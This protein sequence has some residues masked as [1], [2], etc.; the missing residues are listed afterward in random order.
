MEIWIYL[1]KEVLRYVCTNEL[2]LFQDKSG[3]RYNSDSLF[4]YWFINLFTCKGSI[5]DIG[6]GCGI[7]GLLIK[8]DFV[9][10][11]VDMIDIQER[12]I[13]LSKKN[14]EENSLHVNIKECDFLNLDESKKYDI[15]ISNPPFYHSGVKKSENL[16]IAKSR[17]SENLPF[18]DFI[19]K[20]FK[21]L[22][23]KGY[24]YFCYDAKQLPFILKA[25]IDAN[26]GTQEICFLHPKAHKEASLV[27]IRA[28]KSSKALCKVL[29]P[30]VINNEN[31]YTQKAKEVFIKANTL[32][33]EFK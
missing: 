11:D 24:I 25:L 6:C 32:S 29:P 9:S 30:F 22:K 33:C 15:A 14:A 13:F 18:G 8:R 10:C 2:T 26:F 16:Q 21:I 7:L 3:Y 1:K 20:S 12:N 19:K 23:Q 28:R 31:G 4:L 17:Y 27:L 5:L